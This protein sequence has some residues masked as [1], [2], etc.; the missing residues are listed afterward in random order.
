MTKQTL[1]KKFVEAVER[2]KTFK[3]GTYYWILPMDDDKNDWAIVLGYSDGF[4]EKEQDE[5]TDGTWRL[6]A[7]F[8]FQPNNS[9]MQCDYD[10]DWLMPYDEETNEVDDRTIS[11]YSSTDLVETV[12]WLWKQYKEYKNAL[13][14]DG[15]WHFTEDLRKG[16]RVITGL[17]ND[18]EM[19]D[20][21][22][23]E[24]MREAMKEE[25]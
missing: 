22:I 24:Y 20:E 11:I 21:E 16:Y 5:F 19:T 2:M 9:I 13:Y 6:C 18:E 23:K 17:D 14:L 25:D 7:K 4:D 12:D 3:D 15:K 1:T 8:A 10:T